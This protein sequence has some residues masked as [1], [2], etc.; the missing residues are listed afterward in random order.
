MRIIGKV[1]PQGLALRKGLLSIARFLWGR[2]PHFYLLMSRKDCG[3]QRDLSSEMRNGGELRIGDGAAC[4][5]RVGKPR[6]RGPFPRRGTGQGDARDA[7]GRA[8]AVGISQPPPERQDRFCSHVD[9]TH[10]KERACVMTEAWLSTH[11]LSAGR[12][13]RRAGGIV[14]A[15]LLGPGR[16]D[17]GVTQNR[18]AADPGGA[19]PRPA[20]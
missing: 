11:L 16:A 15:C 13:P 4:P 10:S 2:V 3:R 5:C 20:A 7:S 8:R 1:S 19:V 9:E 18:A 17:G 12:G 14:P 6:G